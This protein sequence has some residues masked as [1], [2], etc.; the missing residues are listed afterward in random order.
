MDNKT[1]SGPADPMT[2][3]AEGMAAMHEIYTGMRAA[4]FTLFE[5]AAIIGAMIAN[6]ANGEKPSS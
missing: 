6:S 5:A 3:A 1:N 2:P 4:G